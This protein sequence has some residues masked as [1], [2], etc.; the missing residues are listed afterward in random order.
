L[1]LT[2]EVIGARGGGGG[3]GEEEGEERLFATLPGNACCH[4][5][6]QKHHCS[7]SS[8][9]SKDPQTRQ[10][11]LLSMMML[12]RL[13]DVTS[14]RNLWASRLMRCDHEEIELDT[15]EEFG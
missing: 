15:I 5:R 12:I 9:T 13:D 11:H 1:E 3:G 14:T 10:V 8:K 7:G 6:R 4:C 2:E